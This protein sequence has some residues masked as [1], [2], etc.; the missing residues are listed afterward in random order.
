MIM[1]AG[2]GPGAAA[3]ARVVAQPGVRLRRGRE[4]M[5]R[6]LE[7]FLE[8]ARGSGRDE[9]PEP[10]TCTRGSC[11]CGRG[12]VLERSTRRRLRDPKTLEVALRGLV[13]VGAGQGS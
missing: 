6:G 12:P 7:G 8:T 9:T 3:A 4:G 10:Q 11:C 2:A 13:V 1:G 5:S